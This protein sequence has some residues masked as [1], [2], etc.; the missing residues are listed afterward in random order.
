MPNRYSVACASCRYRS[1]YSSQWEANIDVAAHLRD[2][3]THSVRVV[4]ER[5]GA[6]TRK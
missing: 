2:T 6:T 4:E 3:P 1:S 5:Q